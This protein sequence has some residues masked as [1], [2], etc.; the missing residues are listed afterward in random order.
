MSAPEDD[1]NDRGKNLSE[2]VTIAIATALSKELAAVQCMLDGAVDFHA[3]GRG[4]GRAYTLGEIPAKGGGTHVVAVLMA[5]QGNSTAAANATRVIDHFPSVEVVV[6]VGIAGGV[7]NPAKVDQHV[8]LGDIVASGEGGVVNYAFVKQQGEVLKPRHPP[9]PPDAELLEAARRLEAGAL[10]GLR[11]WETHVERAR[12]LKHSAR[13]DAAA[14]V[15]FDTD[16]PA[17]IVPHPVDDERIEGQPRI[18]LGTIASADR[19]LKDAR[20]RDTLRDQHDVRAVEM[21]SF[22]VA[23]ATWKSRAGF[24]T[25]RGIC[26]YCDGAKNDV[27]QA[28]AAIIAAAYARALLGELASVDRRLTTQKKPERF[29]A[30][31]AEVDPPSTGSAPANQ[32]GLTTNV[33]RIEVSNAAVEAEHQAQLD[34]ILSLIRVKGHPSLALTE[35]DALRARIWSGASEAVRARIVALGGIAKIDL[36]DITIGANALIEALSHAPNDAKVRANAAYGHSLLGNSSAAI[37]WSR[38]ALALDPTNTT[39]IQVA[40]QFDERAAEDVFEEYERIV[41]ARADVAVALAH[42]AGLQSNHE[43]T[44][45]WLE[46]AAKL[47]PSSTDIGADLGRAILNRIAS[48]PNFQ[49]RVDAREAA[50]LERANELLER[51]WASLADDEVRQAHIG[52]LLVQTNLHRLLRKDDASTLADEAV[53]LSKGSLDAVRVRVAIAAESSDYAKIVELLESLVNRPLEETGLLATAYS[54]LRRW[55][56]ALTL[57]RAM[58]NHRDLEVEARQQ[59]ERNLTLTLLEAGRLDE[60]RNEVARLVG[61]APNS[62]ANVLLAIE[63]YEQLGDR[64][65]RDGLLD[66]AVTLISRGSDRHLLIRLGDALLRADRPGAAADVYGLIV[67]A[68]VDGRP[69]RKLIEALYRAGR[70][71]TA[72]AACRKLTESVGLNRFCAEM[73]SVIH[74]E[75]GNLSEARQIC[76]QYVREKGDAPGIV[77]RLGVI[78]QRSGDLASLRQILGVVDIRAAAADIQLATILSYLFTEAGRSK[79]ALDVL[80]EMRRQNLGKAPAHLTYLGR[81]PSLSRDLSKPSVVAPDVAV[82]LGGVGAPAWIL[83]SSASDAAIDTGEYPVS[84]PTSLACLNKKVG[85]VVTFAKTPDKRWTVDEIDTREAFAYRQSLELFPARFPEEPGLE[86]HAIPDNMEEFVE[87][88]RQRLLEGEPR[89]QAIIKAY[90]EGRISIG[91]FAKLA[92]RSSTEAIGVVAAS[93]HGLIA[94][95]NRG[96]EK[97]RALEVLQGERELVADFTALSILNGLGLLESV[98][99]AR[100]LIVARSTVDEFRQELLSLKSLPSDSHMTLGIRDGQ[101]TRHVVDAADV[102]R[103]RLSLERMIQHIDERCSVV[104]VAPAVAQAHAEHRQIGPMI[105]ESFW[106]TLL[107]SASSPRVLLSDDLWLRRLASSTVKADGVCTANVL[108]AMVASGAL[109][110]ATYSEAL[111]KLIASGYRHIATDGH[112]LHAAARLEG[113]RPQGVFVRVADT[114]RDADEASAVGVGVEFMRL[115]WVTIVLPEQRNMLCTTILNALATGRRRSNVLTLVRAQVARAFGLLPVGD[116]EMR[117]LIDAWDRSQIVR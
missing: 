35:L 96:P 69:T 60:A 90:G 97:Q 29:Y 77:V 86:Q 68:S 47:D 75:L 73:A 100:R 101:I 41:G 14:D 93:E 20:T 5:D 76:E 116:V 84:H 59:C 63:A 72:L 1:A 12:E 111:V 2:R 80:F 58:L 82:K 67:D 11:P 104:G 3:P 81:F 46:R 4:A 52:W 40:I 42:R 115:L 27:W 105:G 33:I 13:P 48:V 61:D 36:G 44:V 8:R 49:G 89:S 39:A 53:R 99:K 108:L 85:D 78:L 18:F 88:I 95:T 56:D 32:T 15:L 6:M 57:F 110:R 34:R 28:Y 70:F 30:E 106:H 45:N 38:R 107:L 117:A 19:L 50:E 17:L 64:E 66:R 54:N 109:D 112:V 24:F 83:I 16:D 37:E 87:T 103:R 25:V 74:E 71:D 114:L 62:A 9:R 98:T 21:E 79:D 10:R 65:L 51:A 102:E 43:Q 26:D 113:Y 91:A 22:G 23:E 92:H 31:N 7:P 94:C 55:D